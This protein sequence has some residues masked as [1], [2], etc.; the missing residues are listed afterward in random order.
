[1]CFINPGTPIPASLRKRRVCLS[2]QFMI[3]R[4]K[5]AKTKSQLKQKVWEERAPGDVGLDE[6]F[7]IRCFESSKKGPHVAYDWPSQITWW[8]IVFFLTKFGHINPNIHSLQHP[9]QNK[10]S[11]YYQRE[12]HENQTRFRHS[13][14]RKH[15]PIKKT[16]SFA[17]DHLLYP[18]DV[19]SYPAYR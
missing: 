15:S 14:S 1:M 16:Q 4:S 5:R 6:G 11:Q 8:Q 9:F 7:R 12:P 19:I 17:P 10:Q 2:F 13:F 3:W 18:L